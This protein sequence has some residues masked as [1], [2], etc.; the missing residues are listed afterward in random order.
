MGFKVIENKIGNRNQEHIMTVA[1]LRPEM[2][3]TKTECLFGHLEKGLDRPSLSI[4]TDY[5]FSTHLKIRSNKGGPASVFKLSNHDFHW[6]S[7]GLNP[8]GV[9][10]VLN[11]L[12]V[13][14]HPAIHLGS[15]DK[16]ADPHSLIA[17]PEY[18]IALQLA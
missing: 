10:M 17:G 5:L 13:D 3:L 12:R 11:R 16:L 4:I 7:Y 8:R 2:T 15:P 1:F 9:R 14:H 18:K 6:R